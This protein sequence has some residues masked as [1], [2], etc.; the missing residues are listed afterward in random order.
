M[1]DDWRISK[2]KVVVKVG[3]GQG[4]VVQSETIVTAAH[5]LPRFPPCFSNR[6]DRTFPK[7]VSSLDGEPNIWAQCLFA[8]PVANIAV[9]GPPEAEAGFYDECKAYNTLLQGIPAVSI[10]DATEE[11]AAYLLTPDN[12]WSRCTVSHVRYAGAPLW[13]D[14]AA[15][16]IFGSMS[17]SPIMNE[18]GQAIGV[19]SGISNG[20]RCGGPNPRLVSHLP[21]WLLQHLACAPP[22]LEFG[23]QA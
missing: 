19:V 8:D 16:G 11:G 23:A 17:G 9:L 13:I 4:F 18:N 14:D 1:M 3:S 12:T 5:C 21:G 7:L 2:L 10:A 22:N 6:E 15:E 20:A